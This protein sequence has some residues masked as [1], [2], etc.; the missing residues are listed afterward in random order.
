[1]HNAE[2]L[3]MLGRPTTTAADERSELQTPSVDPTRDTRV[4]VGPGGQ[5]VGAAG[6]FDMAPHVSIYNWCQVHP[7]HHGEGI[8]TTLADWAEN[9]G[10]ASIEL[11]PPDARVTLGQ[12]ILSTHSDAKEL[13]R[14]RGFSPVRYFSRLQ[15]E[16]NAAPPEP[17]VPEGI[18]IRPSGGDAELPRLVHAFEDAFRDHWGF[19]EQPFEDTLREFQAWIKTSPRYD[20]SLWLVAIESDEMVGVAMAHAETAEDPDMG[21][22]SELGVR[23]AWRKRGIGTALLFSL[24]SEFRRRGLRRAALDVDAES[25]TGAT[26]LYEGVGFHLERQAIAMEKELRPGR[27]LRTRTSES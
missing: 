21:Y 1:V 6:I 8:G 11:A 13:L 2:T 12:E 20:P 26:S 17:P 4:V 22:I 25:L 27:D 9:R 14:N 15:M 23:R 3:E 24:L 7:D 16:L 18:V 10:R 19:V 5:I